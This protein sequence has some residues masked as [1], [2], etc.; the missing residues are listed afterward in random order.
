MV[1]ILKGVMNLAL[2]TEAG[3]ENKEPRKKKDKKKDKKSKTEEVLKAVT[4]SSAA[5]DLRKSM[6]EEKRIKELSASFYEMQSKM[7]NV[8]INNKGLGEELTKMRTD[9]SEINDTMRNLLCIY[10]V[11]TKSNNPFVSGGGE[12]GGYSD[13]Q[14]AQARAAEE[15][16]ILD[17]GKKLGASEMLMFSSL[18]QAVRKMENH[19]ESI[20]QKRMGGGDAER[21]QLDGLE[22]WYQELKNVLEMYRFQPK[23]EKMTAMFEG[24]EEEA[25]ISGSVRKAK[26]GGGN[27]A[28][29]D[30]NRLLTSI[31]IT[32]HYLEKVI[33]QKVLGKDPPESELDKLDYW[34]QEFV[35]WR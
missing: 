13:I 16:D 10:E 34:Y 5:K 26:T 22:S 35:N 4:P 32:E 6:E 23:R 21:A 33:V 31:R 7:K 12:Y 19:M 24:E 18:F 1:D 30:T 9:L 29:R 20:F 27:F 15:E 2:A 8:E 14:A 11:I 17:D 25:E 3:E 28:S